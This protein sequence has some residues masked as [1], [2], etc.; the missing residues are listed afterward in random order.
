[1]AKQPRTQPSLY[2]PPWEP[3]ILLRQ[4]WT[5]PRVLHTHSISLQSRSY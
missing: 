2:A 3:Q 4:L 5:L 1:V